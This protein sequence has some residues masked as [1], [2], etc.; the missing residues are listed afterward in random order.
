MQ[1]PAPSTMYDNTYGGPINIYGQPVMTV[2][3]R[4]QNGSLEQQQ[5]F[6]NG[7]IFMAGEAVQ[8]VASYLWGYMPAPLRGVQTQLSPPPGSGHV[9][10]SFV[11]GDK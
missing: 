6:N 10:V 11:P 9:S 2:L 7:L 1:A 4:P 3:P 8:N 5:Q